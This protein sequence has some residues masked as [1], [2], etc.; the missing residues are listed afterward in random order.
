MCVYTCCS[1]RIGLSIG[2]RAFIF[3]FNLNATMVIQNTEYRI[4]NTEYRIQ[5]TEYRTQN[6]EYRIQNTERRACSRIYKPYE[7]VS[8]SVQIMRPHRVSENTEYRI[9]NREYRIQNTEY[10]IQNTE[11]RTQNTE[12][13]I[14]NTEY[15]IQNTEYRIQNTEDRIQNTEY[16]IQMSRRMQNT[17]YSIQMSHRIQNTATQS[18]PASPA[19]QPSPPRF[20]IFAGRTKRGKHSRESIEDNKSVRLKRTHWRTLSSV[21]MSFLGSACRFRFIFK[22]WTS[23]RCLFANIFTKMTL[24]EERM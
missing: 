17:E 21:A 18:S 2:P 24:L 1:S 3:S 7:S 22:L 19:S 16:R 13:R 10:R 15:R 14:Q 12:Y 4:Q 9:Q 5:N 6:T 20:C 23:Q 11:Y 8:Q